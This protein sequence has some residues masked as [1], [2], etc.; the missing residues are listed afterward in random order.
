MQ[1]GFVSN[2]PQNVWSVYSLPL[3][4]ELYLLVASGLSSDVRVSRGENRNE[5]R[6]YCPDSASNVEWFALYPSKTQN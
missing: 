4:G 6:F 1:W 5:L 3:A 2:V